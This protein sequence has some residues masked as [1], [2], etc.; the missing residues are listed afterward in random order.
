MIIIL[1]GR[2]MGISLPDTI[3]LENDSEKERKLVPS[4]T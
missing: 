4:I 2:K 1:S 3:N